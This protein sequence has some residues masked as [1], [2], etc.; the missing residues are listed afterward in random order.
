MNEFSDGSALKAKSP[1][2]IATLLQAEIESARDCDRHEYRESRERA[3][4]YFLGDMEDT[5]A[6]DGRSHAQTSDTADVVEWMLPGLDRLFFGSGD[7]VKYEPRRPDDEEGSKQATEYVN[8]LID[9]DG[10]GRAALK[11]GMHD[12]LVV[13]KGII[14]A[15]M[16][17]VEEYSVEDYSGLIEDALADLVSDDAVEVIA[18]SA[19][20][21][22]PEPQMDPQTGQPVMVPVML[23]DV[24]L[25]RTQ[26]RR[27]LKVSAVPPENFLI[28]E[29]ATSICK[30]RFLCHRER[31][32]RTDL[33]EA[34]YDFDQVMNLP[35]LSLSELDEDNELELVRENG[36]ASF[37]NLANDK[38][39][40]EIDVHECYI[41]ADLD[42]DGL[43]EWSKVVVAGGYAERNILSIE[44]WGDPIPFASLDPMPVPHRW[45]GRSVAD[46][47]M[48]IQQIKTVLL[49]QTLD[50]IYEQ[51][52]PQKV[53][54]E[55]QVVNPEAVIQPRFNGV[56][57]VKGT[58]DGRT[59][60]Q[61]LVPNF[62]AETSFSMLS[63]L[64][65]E[66]EART[67]VSRSTMALDPEALQNQTAEAVRAG[68]DAQYSKIELIAPNLAQG[69]F[70]DFFRIVLKLIVKHQDRPEQIRLRGE[71]VEMDPR[72]WNAEM[73]V[74][75]NTGLG[76]G[77]RERDLAML[78]QVYQGQVGFAQALMGAGMAPLAA[79]AVPPSKML[80]TLKQAAQAAGFRD[81][82][83]FFGELTEE[84]VANFMQ[85]QSQEEKPDPE[86]AKAQGQLQIAQMK[87][88]AD[89]QLAQQKA[90]ADLQA[91]REKAQIDV[92]A[93]RER[94]GLEIQMMRDKAAAELQISREKAAQDAQLR[95][96]EM[97]I[98]AELTRQANEMKAAQ[99]AQAHRDN[100]AIAVEK[101]KADTNI[102]GVQ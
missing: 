40:D 77:S 47:T 94:A 62:I 29:G 85:A 96:E 79:K 56:I 42:G 69:G 46:S 98:E 15:T 25:R 92:E 36:L 28:N 72:A 82:D 3:L 30:A 78:M 55:N 48:D 60:V 54:V 24:R 57:R 27:R 73:D 52:H 95:R 1:R 7:T 13:R 64:D 91:Q 90:A 76:T 22:E 4:A 41:K 70:R 9:T 12:A 63:Y 18:H 34:G 43:A 59:A 5:P 20:P 16:E 102:N 100:H 49:R 31:M 89:A 86:M 17:T 93:A 88:E 26:T 83:Q 71:W 75:I 84:D 23:H 44:E 65:A 81:P 35:R 58:A 53:V 11:A 38:S 19:Y 37:R 101:A 32:T 74:T 68:K 45:V 61:S 8:W 14:K 33:I 67:G 99:Q 2:E 50:N 80:T 10:V 51:N 6:E 39:M 87:A 21:G 66:K 97:Q